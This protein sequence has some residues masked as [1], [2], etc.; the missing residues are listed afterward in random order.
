MA[1]KK[2]EEKVETFIPETVLEDVA[3]EEGKGV[4]DETQV[5]ET[6]PEETTEEVIEE[7]VLETPEVVEEISNEST[8][9]DP[10]R[11][12][13]RTTKL[14]DEYVEQLLDKFEWVTIK[15]HYDTLESNMELVHRVI[16]TLK[17]E[18]GIK[19]IESQR[20]HNTC[21]LKVSKFNA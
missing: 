9:E 14:H 7:P 4:E 13:G 6:A 3:V 11:K 17:E 21:K 5:V 19:T 2:E 16:T 18:H 20:L 8:E 1:K 12:T 15:D 10:L